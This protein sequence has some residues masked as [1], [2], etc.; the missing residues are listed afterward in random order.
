M[1]SRKN[2]SADGSSRM[3]NGSVSWIGLAMT[4]IVLAGMSGA[5]WW[6]SRVNSRMA[7]GYHDVQT[8]SVVNLMADSAEGFLG[9]GDLSRLRRIVTQTSQA[10]G[11]VACRIV[12]G[13]AVLA[14]ME[15][16]RITPLKE[17]RLEEVLATGPLEMAP[18]E[19]MSRPV[20]VPG[21]G[22]ARLEITPGDVSNFYAG[23]PWQ[24]QAELA[25][26][27]V[28][29]LLMV[30]WLY[31][32]IRR[33]ERSMGTIRGALLSR[34]ED[35]TGTALLK[36]S[37]AL[38]R[39]ANAWNDLL[40]EM[41]GLRRELLAAQ[42]VSGSSAGGESHGELMVACDS[43]PQGLVV[44]DDENL[45]R[46]ANGAAGAFLQLAREEMLGQ[47]VTELIGG[48]EVSDA[49]KKMAR[50]ESRQRLIAEVKRGE[51]GID[52]VLRFVVRPMR[53]HDSGMAMIV[54]EDVTQQR[55]AEESRNA[56]VAQATHELRTPLSNI[57]LYVE[58]AIEDGAEDEAL[59]QHSLNVINQEAQR[60]NRVVSD[61]LS[62]SEIE[63]GA[64]RLSLD[65]LR[66]EG[67]FEQIQAEY[68][69]Q[70]DEKN[71]GLV[72]EL[73][74][75]LPV[76]QA[77]RDKVLQ[78]VHN[79][80]SNAIKY[81]PESG[82]VRVSVSAK[83]GALTVAVED[84]GVGI[85]AEDQERVFEK[86]YR[87]DDA[88]LSETTGSG[89]GLAIAREVIRLHGGDITVESQIDRGSRFTLTMPIALGVG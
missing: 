3:G 16:S 77:D 85:A 70:A 21:I 65:D 88:R 68:Q 13:G 50:G 8:V 15:P 40:K 60:L 1:M 41:D 7:D 76:I 11:F 52:G 39:E 25:G 10:H 54:I 75:K 33:R 27:A 55:V 57:V 38:G 47:D 32:V 2:I 84:S 66:L 5:G 79:L 6:V 49:L 86:F 72:F 17:G 18:G 45:V 82:E 14:D 67:V 28:G 64:R 89:L 59:M 73:P 56:F 44:V 78:A 34:R 4:L 35:D 20:I 69:P 51:D 29:T 23:M 48:G 24:W 81:T 26:V 31:R 53:E 42:T 22:T 62:V 43:L 74:P 37:S 61:M 83:D 87:T 46:Y 36:V 12:A 9:S 58:S 80:V 63:A 30:L 71:I 19:A